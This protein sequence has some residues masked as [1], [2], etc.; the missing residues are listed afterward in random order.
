MIVATEV[1]PGFLMELNSSCSIRHS[2]DYIRCMRLIQFDQSSKP[3]LKLQM[4][5][6]CTNWKIID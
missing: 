5:T 4:G 1:R 6:T 3:G 2:T